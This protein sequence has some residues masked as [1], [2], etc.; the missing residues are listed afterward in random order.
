[1]CHPYTKITGL[2]RIAETNTWNDFLE[3]EIWA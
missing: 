3:K 1:M 2:T